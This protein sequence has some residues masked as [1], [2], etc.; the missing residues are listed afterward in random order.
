MSDWIELEEA[1]SRLESRVQP[2]G[3]ERVPLLHA[4]GRV[5]AADIEADRDFP[6]FDRAAMDGYAVRSDDVRNA[7]AEVPVALEVI[8]ESTPGRGWEGDAR[9]GNAIRIMTGAPVPAG[10]DSVVPVESTSGFDRQ[11]VQVFR[12]VASGQNIAARALERRA[13]DTVLERGQRLRAVDVGILAMVGAAEVPVFAAPRIALWSTGDELVAFDA[14]PR[15]TQIRNS[16][17]PMLAALAQVEGSVAMLGAVADTPDATL[18]A[19]QRGL[20]FDLLL[21]TGGVSMGAYDWVGQALDAA[22]VRVHFR[23]VA[24]QPG[25]PVLFGTHSGGVVLALPGNPVSAY[26]TFRLFAQPVLRRLQ[27]AQQVR[28]TWLRASARFEWQRRAP[29]CILLPG[30]LQAAGAAVERVPYSGSGDLMAYARA[31]C[32]IV[33]PTEVERVQAG[34]PVRVWP[35]EAPFAAA[36]STSETS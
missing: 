23:R 29:K 19:V 6:P 32:Q 22:G 36:V 1:W 24:L 28:P 10:W 31:D 5:L 13:G 30:R 3:I 21:L 9:A 34:Q 15:P 7:S 17:A 2:L 35:L 18:A 11:R 20:S 16:N 33:L 25:K 14:C 12:A 8:G 26:T 4:C 27:G